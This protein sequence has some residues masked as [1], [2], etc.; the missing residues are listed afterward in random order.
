MS[1][2]EGAEDGAAQAVFVRRFELGGD[3]PR[4]AIKDSI[5]VQG[6]PTRM[7][8]ASLADAPP[9]AQ[10][11]A[12]VRTLL[13]AGCRIVGKTNMHELAYG[14]TGINRFTGTPRNPRA[15]GRIPGGSSTGSAVAVA[16][17]MVEFAIGTDTGGSI[18]IPAACCGIVGLKPTFGRISRAGVHPAA[19]SLDRVGAFPRDLTTRERAMTALDPTFRPRP[20]PTAAVLGRLAST[21]SPAIDA[22][23]DAALDAAGMRVVPIEL[24]SFTRAFGAALDIL[25][26]EN[27]AAFGALTEGPLLGPDVR[28]RLLAARDVTPAQ[29]AA[30]EEVRRALRAEIDAALEHVDALALPT[31]PDLPPTLEAA[32]DARASL[33]I[34]ALVRQFNLSGHPAVSLPIARAAEAPV[35]L[36]LIGRHGQDEALVALARALTAGLARG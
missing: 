12:V 8:S 24:P 19:A 7:A 20:A 5:D 34:T 14:V 9:A 13:E 32:A 30:A 17:G 1:A 31:L 4:V 15:P 25:G 27:W 16:L 3:G 11:A 26:A 10:H 36:Q 2:A 6:H 23:V 29:V 21:A 35:G 28:A 18:R 33:G 22:A